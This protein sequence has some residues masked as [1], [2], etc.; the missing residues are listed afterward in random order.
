MTDIE[1]YFKQVET[2]HRWAQF[3]QDRPQLD[4]EPRVSD[5]TGEKIRR[6]ITSKTD[7]AIEAVYQEAR[8][9][10]EETGVVHHVDHIFPVSKGG[11]HCANNL[12]VIPASENVRK[13]ASVER[14]FIF[15]VQDND[16][17][18]H[19]LSD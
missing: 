12:R 16:G 9:R 11:A 2:R 15:L 17:K 10:T 1:T 14:E 18:W 3:R 4:W 5:W 7:P 6:L 19:P 8:R 13:A